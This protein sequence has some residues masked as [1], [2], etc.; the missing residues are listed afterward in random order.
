M[1]TTA[2]LR[3]V[4]L[5]IL[6]ALSASAAYARDPGQ[7]PASAQPLPTAEQ[8]QFIVPV[9]LLRCFLSPAQINTAAGA[10]GHDAQTTVTDPAF[11][12]GE[13]NPDGS[14]RPP[15]TADQFAALAKMH[16]VLDEDMHSGAVIRKFI[17]NSDVGGFLYG[18][19]VIGSP[20]SPVVVTTDTVRGFIGLERNTQGLDAGETVGALGLDYESTPTGQ[21]TDESPFP[22]HRQVAVEVIVYGLHSIRHHMSAQGASDARIPLARD[23][24]DSV[25]ASTPSLDDRS[26]EM[27]RQGQTNPYTGLGI[28][29]NIGLLTL[30]P[31][32]APE[33]VYPLHLNEEDVMTVPTPLISGDELLRRTVEGQETMIARYVKITHANGTVIH[34]WDLARHLS[35]ADRAYYQGLI[36]QAAARVA[37][38][39]G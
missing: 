28:S 24:N 26:F 4:L 16:S 15:L 13:L 23:L 17:A 10:I 36:Q 25:G 29:D 11:E 2:S 33:A 21:F 20:S 30:R 8:R 14:L 22:Y 39:G 31:D 19:T 7:C 37:A 35:A 27:N 6:V 38:A 5:S 3:A 12:S 32:D 1:K 18:R 9:K 34:R